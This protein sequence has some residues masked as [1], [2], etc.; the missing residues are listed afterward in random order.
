VVIDNDLF[1]E[2]SSTTEKMSELSKEIETQFDFVVFHPSRI[3]IRSD[4][5]EIA[6]GDWKASHLLLEG[7][8]AFIQRHKDARIGLMLIQNELAYDYRFAR[9]RCCDLDIEDHVMWLDPGP[10][11]FFSRREMAQLYTM[12]DV[13]AVDFG[14]G[15]F[16]VSALEGLSVGRP[17]L[18]YL[19]EDVMSK[20]YPWHPMINVR[21]PG[22]IA[23][24]LDR[25]YQDPDYRLE[26]GKKGREWIR[27]FHAPQHALKTYAERIEALV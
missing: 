20:L 17:I 19:D 7:F 22:D 8:A 18:N 24:A 9:K 14:I 26:I 10:A 12:A 16:G 3:S 21:N 2:T 4:E 13:V 11:G 27:R 1:A 5:L 15:W 23:A 6:A 25:L